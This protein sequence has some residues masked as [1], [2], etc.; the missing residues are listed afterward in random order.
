MVKIAPDQTVYRRQ[1]AVQPA[2]A[3]APMPHPLELL[4]YRVAS[5]LP[6]CTATLI[7]G[8]YAPAMLM[9]ENCTDGQ[10]DA[11]ATWLVTIASSTTMRLEAMVDEDRLDLLAEG[12]MDCIL[13]QLENLDRRGADRGIG[14]MP[15]LAKPTLAKP[16]LAEPPLAE[17]SLAR[18]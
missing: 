2:E 17:P 9:V 7:V 14:P 12:S 3:D 11:T 4:A 8:C 10:P 13:A 16:T 6:G 15:T 1:T 5:R 18:H